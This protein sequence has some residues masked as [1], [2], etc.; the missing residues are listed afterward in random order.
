MK[1]SRPRKLA[2]SILVSVCLPI[3]LVVSM[4]LFTYLAIFRE[5][6]VN[7]PVRLPLIVFRHLLETPLITFLETFDQYSVEMRKL[8]LET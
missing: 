5:A 3:I 7:S 8:W 1:M 4:T 6:Q 2:I